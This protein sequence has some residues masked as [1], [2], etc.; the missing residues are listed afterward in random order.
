MKKQYFLY[1]LL[2]L[3]ILLT[4][5]GQGKD[6][7]KKAPVEDGI[8]TVDVDTDSSMFHINEAL[9][10]KCTM[11][12]KDGKMTVHMTLASKKITKLFY[13]MA[14]DAKK[15]GAALIEPT[16]D[17]VTYSDGMKEEAYG[18]DVPVPYLDEEFDVAI[19]GS[20]DNWYD[21]KVKVSNPV[22]KADQ[23]K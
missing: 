5:C 8:Y 6:E 11:T 10:G 15:D 17:T 18:F 13:G 1:F 23:S 22:P 7:G 2:I 19:L 3:C 21:H 12:V 20:K 4:A 14:E 16:T 9:E